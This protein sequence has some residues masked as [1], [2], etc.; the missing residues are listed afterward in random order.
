VESGVKRSSY[1]SP[2]RAAQ[3]QATRR[4]IVAAAAGLFVERGYGAT[5]VD[6]IA[7]AAG[8]SRKTV[9]TSV[10]GKAAA[11]KLALD[12]AI[13]GDDAPVAMM[14]R[15]Q[16]QAQMREPDARRLLAL[17]AQLNAEVGGRISELQ[18]VVE[19][20]A[21]ADEEL[22]ALAETLAAQRR[23]GMGHLAE[24]LDQRGA[25]RPDLSVD[26][27]ADVLWLMSGPANYRWFVVVQGWSPLRFAGWL[28]DALAS[29]LVD[30]AYRSPRTTGNK[31]R[32]RATGASDD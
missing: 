7:E 22:R 12:W 18:H 1:Q 19:A 27:A 20:A 15:P 10:G 6:A 21:G 25:L 8:V 17:Y 4:A 14:D 11:L 32:R 26:E 29:L 31:P 16:V 9:F 23:F 28:G 24:Q 3:A 30:P 2:L 13:V 5:S